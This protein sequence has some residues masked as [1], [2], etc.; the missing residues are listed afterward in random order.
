MKKWQRNKN[1]QEISNANGANLHLP[2]HAPLGDRLIHPRQRHP[3]VNGS[4]SRRSS[5]TT[6]R[7][8]SERCG[9]T[10]SDK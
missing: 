10:G 7:C 3:P 2:P 6:S 4:S 8:P 1:T 5:T 9:T